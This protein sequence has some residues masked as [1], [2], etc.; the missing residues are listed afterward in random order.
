[1]T[2]PSLT[3]HLLGHLPESYRAATTHAFLRD[4][5]SR[6]ITSEEL[7]FWLAQD[8]LYAAHAYPRFIGLLIAKIPFASHH[9]IT[10]PEE[11]HNQRI[12]AVLASAMSNIVREATFFQ[13]ISGRYGLDLSSWAERKETR[14]YKAEM[15]SVASVGTLAEGLV[16]LWAME[17]VGFEQ[18]W[19]GEYDKRFVLKVY[20]DAWWY[21]A[22]AA[23]STASE[24]PNSHKSAI[25][26]L[27]DNWTNSDF[28]AF[29]D[30]I[31]SLVNEM[32]L[33]PGSDA[34]KRAEHAWARVLELEIA[35][36]PRHKESDEGFSR[37]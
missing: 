18:I 16:F 7:S 4:V 6:S 23:P 34:W 17:K 37:K 12:L 20:L 24:P 31:G 32:G 2:A 11:K 35:F 25:S 1:M 27:V 10:S 19:F 9:G 36:W 28:E 26:S 5:G 3:A 15:I 14:D 30:D 13:D 33:L 21:A 8:R 29:V 22:S